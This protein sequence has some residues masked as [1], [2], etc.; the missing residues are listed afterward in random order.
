MS[1]VPHA[2]ASI[3]TMPNGSGHTIGN[4]SAAAPPRNSSF[5]GKPISPRNSVEASVKGRQRGQ[6]QVPAYRKMQVVD[7]KVND[8]ELVSLG[9]NGF[10]HHN[11]RSQLIDTVCIE[12]QGLRTCRHQ[13]RLR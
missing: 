10:E 8:I 6:F 7:M 12:P 3:I 13:L 11:L 9:E 5:S 1:G 4:K 2:R